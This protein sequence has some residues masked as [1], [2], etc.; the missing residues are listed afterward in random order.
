MKELELADARDIN[1][2][3]RLLARRSLE[4]EIIESFF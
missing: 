3:R 2:S 1:D 4:K